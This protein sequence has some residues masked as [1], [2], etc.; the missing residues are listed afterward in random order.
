MNQLEQKQRAWQQSLEDRLKLGWTDKSQTEEIVRNACVKAH[1]FG[2][3]QRD[4][5][6]IVQEIIGLPGYQEYCEHQHEIAAY[7]SEWMEVTSQSWPRRRSKVRPLVAKKE[8]PPKKPPKV[9]P[10]STKRRDDVLSRLRQ[11]VAALVD[12]PLPHTVVEIVCVIQDKGKEMFGK[13][14]SRGT[15]YSRQYREEWR[16]LIEIAQSQRSD[17]Q[18]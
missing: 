13:V 4:D 15:L 7:V 10:K 12:Q 2:E 11:T 1:L 5:R 9:Q 8:Q 18:A 3:G 17:R 14:F 16:I 6:A